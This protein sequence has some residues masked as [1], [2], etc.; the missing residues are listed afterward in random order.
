MLSGIKGVGALVIILVVVTGF[1]LWLPALRWF[2]LISLGLG[3]VAAV[4][5]H[6]L[7][8]RP[9]KTPEEKQ[10]RLNLDK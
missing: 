4:I 9:V 10:I 1:L 7:H 2:F 5:L 6:F 3:L 8:K